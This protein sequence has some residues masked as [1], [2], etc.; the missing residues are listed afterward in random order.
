MAEFNWQN[1]EVVNARDRFHVTPRLEPRIDEVISK[2]VGKKIYQQ[3]PRVLK[4]IC[5][6]K[7]NKPENSLEPDNFMENQE[8]VKQLKE[9][10]N[11]N[12]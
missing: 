5:K 3:D 11:S 1:M 9:V 8:F 10:L 7:K 4:F 2:V 12:L 6:W